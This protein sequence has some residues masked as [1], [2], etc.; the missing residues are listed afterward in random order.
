MEALED[1][2]TTTITEST[3]IT[4]R[5]ALFVVF[6]ELLGYDSPLIEWAE[7]W[8]KKGDLE[9]FMKRAVEIDAD[10]IFKKMQGDFDIPKIHSWWESFYD[11]LLGEYDH[12]LELQEKGEFPF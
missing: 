1:K 11:I 6:A 5:K 4:P 2:R 12:S 3:V 7:R 9:P 10:N 8:C